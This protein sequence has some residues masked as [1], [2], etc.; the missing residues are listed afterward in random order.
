MI[1]KILAPSCDKNSDKQESMSTIK[2]PT[3]N[4]N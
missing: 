2:K 3:V 1:L 4:I